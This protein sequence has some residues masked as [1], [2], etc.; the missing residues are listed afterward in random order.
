MRLVQ[1]ESGGGR[2]VALVEGNHLQVLRGFA[3]V[4]ELAQAAIGRGMRLGALAAESVSGRTE[5][6]DAV[7]AGR[8]DW[9]LLP[10]GDHPTEPARC[11]VSGTGLTHLA[12]ASRRDAMHANTAQLTDSMR[13]YLWGEE[14]GRPTAGQA[15]V[16]PEWFYK[17]N[18]TILRAHNQ[19]LLVPRFGEDGGEEPEIAGVYLIDAEGVPRRLG[20]TMGNEF[21]DH[22][23]E[24]RNYLY[25]ASSKLRTC[26][27]GPEL[28]VDAE[29][30]AVAG[31]V[32][33]LRGDQVLWRHDIGSGEARMSHTLANLE[34]HHFKYEQHRRP[35]DVHIHY[36]GADA[37]SFGDGLELAEGDVMQ[38]QFE[39]FG[40][41]LRNPVHIDRS[42]DALVA[43]M[44]C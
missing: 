26:S 38:V 41:P 13:M 15:G 7:Y 20:L 33:I 12:S 24:R 1:L 35:G 9:R 37:F 11:L 10:A 18:G 21:S 32:S 3:S 31:Q 4:Y 25:L 28:V 44:P 6:Y 29:F 23:H 19:P 17:G 22:K 27:I 14:G 39:G 42:P 36:F 8:S 2:C 5:D 40:R 34:H 30:G 16:A 43:V